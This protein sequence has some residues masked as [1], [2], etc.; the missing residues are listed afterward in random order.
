MT[1][2][3]T[4]YD[5]ANEDD[6]ECGECDPPSS[7]A[8]RDPVPLEPDDHAKRAW[9]DELDDDD[10]G[11]PD[12]GGHA[13]AEGFWADYRAVFAEYRMQ[14]DAARDAARAHVAACVKRVRA[15]ARRKAAAHRRAAAASREASRAVDA[16]LRH[17]Q[18]WRLAEARYVNALPKVG[19]Q[20]EE[21]FKPR[22]PTAARGGGRGRGRGRP[23]AGDAP[24]PE[25]APAAAQGGDGRRRRRRRGRGRPDAPA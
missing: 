20:S 9:A 3:H 23:L 1:D 24:A 5:T 11:E 12:D 14:R 8:A 25:P 6:G 22:G 13:V 2:K 7:G 10:D 17:E 18:A 4:D 15:L 16:A 19:T 21:F